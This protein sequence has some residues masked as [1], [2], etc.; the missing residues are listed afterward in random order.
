VAAVIALAALLACKKVW[1]VDVFWHLKSGQWMLTHLRVLGHDPFSV[2]GSDQWVNVHWLFQLL[3]AAVHGLGGFPALVVLKMAV[4]AGTMAVLALW[5]R[6]R[7]GPAWLMLAGLWL[8]LGT[9]AR[10]RVRP[11]IFTFLFLMIT[12]VLL[13]SARRGADT[14]RLWW[15]VPINILW[16]NMHGVFIVGPAA[17]WAAL[18]GAWLDR[19]LKRPAAGGLASRKALLPILVAT[20]ACL[21]SPWP[22]RAALHPLLLATRASGEQ[23]LYAFGVQ[24]LRPTYLI[25][26]FKNVPLLLTAGLAVGVLESL[27]ARRRSVPLGHVLWL[28]MFVVPA[29]LALRNVVLFVVPGAFL[30]GLHGGEW[31]DELSRG[32]PKLAKAGTPARLAMA[33]ALVA[34]A[35]AYVTEAAYRWQR[36][37]AS[38]FGFGL[39][40][41]RHAL[42]IAKWLGR[43]ELSG[44]VLPLEFGDG[45]A[46]I[47]YAFPR[48]KVWIDGRLEVHPRERLE[49]LYEYRVKM[50]SSRTAVDPEEVALP[51]TVRFVTVRLEDW[52]HLEALTNCQDR[53]KLVYVD[54]MAACFARRPVEGEPDAELL[55]QWDRRERLPPSNVSEYDLPLPAD[56]AR[57]MLDVE[58]SRT[59]YRRNTPTIHWT[60]GRLLYFLGRYNLAVRYLT[61]ADRLGLQER[62]RRVG[63]LARAHQALAEYQPIEPESEA[64]DLPADPNLARALALY[65]DLNLT[66]L[67][68]TTARS[69]ALRR[70]RALLLARHIDLALDAMKEYLRLLPIPDRWHPGTEAMRLVEDIKL[71]YKLSLAAKS[72]FDLSGLAPAERAYLLSHKDIG[73]VE[74]AIAEL[75]SAGKLP[76]R[77]RMLLG[78]LYL[79]KGQ[80]RPAREAYSIAAAAETDWA[81]RMRL[82]LCDWAEGRFGDAVVAL[83]EAARSA[84]QAPEPTLYLALL[85]EQLGDYAA[86]AEVL[87]A[88][89]AATQPGT[90]Q[91]SRLLDQVR[92]RMEMRGYDF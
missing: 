65:E 57:P 79:R 27:R 54:L 3:V 1:T 35:L 77:S 74:A 60:L 71:R 59:W 5:L 15:L 86:A 89:P 9:E 19:L 68:D 51:R 91:A 43:S 18:A 4:F 34:V 81:V 36:R 82:G 11:E 69:Y 16:V 50:R 25:N 87:R 17:A 42:R 61:V 80:T 22:V 7:I 52:A 67:S 73:L 84:P 46:L 48:R 92:A 55:R 2:D 85:H 72:N 32:R 56:T 30:L 90:T 10:V 70:L 31:I 23:Q 8:A 64:C 49:K 37:P 76:R 66:D 40:E 63:M 53:F 41:E 13:E 29:V 20:A 44:D 6:R 88:R 38:R 45:G 21:V 39:V 26:P 78:D 47:C 33:A 83:R 62:V 12:L 58:T 75:R 28:A 24:E 14:K